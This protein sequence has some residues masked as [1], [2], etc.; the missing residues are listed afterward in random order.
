MLARIDQELGGGPRRWNDVLTVR[1]VGP[2]LTS[3]PMSGDVIS[4]RG[5]NAILF[6]PG[7][8]PTHFLKVRPAIHGGFEREAA[9]TVELSAN[10]QLRTLVPGSRAF[11]EGPARV[12]AQDF[13]D[14]SALDVVI[15]SR[16]A[17][18][19]HEL[20]ADVLRSTA[21]LH[22]AI[23]DL[24]GTGTESQHVD[25]LRSDLE[26]LESLGLDASA[27]S[28]L[29]ARLESASLPGG[30][31]HGDFWPRNVLRTE[32]G[33]RVIDFESC[34]EV[35]TP[36]YDVLHF[37]R[38]CG[39]AVDG[40]RGLWI[41]HWL[42]AGRASRPLADEVRRAAADLDNASIEAALIAYEV[43]FAATLHRRGIAGERIV[44]RLRELDA[45]PKLLD[46]GVV[47]RLLG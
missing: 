41:S 31:Q 15:R 25:G 23:R 11:V 1:N 21:P 38:G 40:G 47:P 22:E 42:D 24:A 35:A 8:H 36:L 17:G 37:V 28:A 3:A 9:V 26:L 27:S 4:N 12:L 5:F 34:G 7:G 32:S 20:A 13:I 19:W 10:P 43:R 30:P 39:E 45:L 33:S 6:A 46:E 16:R 2:L 29:G 18:A 44:G 14:G